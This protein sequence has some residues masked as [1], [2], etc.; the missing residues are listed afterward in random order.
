MGS[1]SIFPWLMIYSSL[2]ASIRYSPSSTQEMVTAYAYYP[3]LSQALQFTPI[4][5]DASRDAYC[6]DRIRFL[7]WDLF[8]G[9]ECCAFTCTFLLC[10]HHSGFNDTRF[11]QQMTIWTLDCSWF[12]SV[13]NINDSHTASVRI[14]SSS[15]LTRAQCVRR[16]GMVLYF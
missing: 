4:V 2:L 12:H 11:V 5:E 9:C 16:L 6:P 1:V 15:T 7:Q 13:S 3:S 14:G 10:H 8:C